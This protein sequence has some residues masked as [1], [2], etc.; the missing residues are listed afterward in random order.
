MAK[1]VT[2]LINKQRKTIKVTDE[3][4]AEIIKR[5]DLE[6]DRMTTLG[7]DVIPAK[8]IVAVSSEGSSE[9]NR[10]KVKGMRRALI[11]A[12]AT[13]FLCKGVGFVPIYR[14]ADGNVLHE[15]KPKCEIVMT[16]CECQRRVKTRFGLDPE[17]MTWFHLD[18]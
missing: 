13:C 9:I 11:D 14:D 18:E 16:S 17:D 6:P 8:C 4:A 15:W 10:E 2:Y 5:R 3:Q 1:I 7:V 12:A